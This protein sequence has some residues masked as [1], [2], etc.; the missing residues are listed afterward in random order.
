TVPGSGRGLQPRR[1][2]MTPLAT[3]PD[4]PPATLT[5]TPAPMEPIPIRPV[6]DL[7]HPLDLSDAIMVPTHTLPAAPTRDDL[8]AF[9][10]GAVLALVLGFIEENQ[11]E[12]VSRNNAV[13]GLPFSPEATEARLIR[14]VVEGLSSMLREWAGEGPEGPT[15]N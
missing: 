10:L 4:N 3:A 12:I 15:S 9:G 1:A 13:V 14:L 5:T 8:R 11:E 2:R 7:R 6:A